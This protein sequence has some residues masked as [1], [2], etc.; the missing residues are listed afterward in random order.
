MVMYSLLSFYRYYTAQPVLA[1][2]PS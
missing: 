2:T 1:G